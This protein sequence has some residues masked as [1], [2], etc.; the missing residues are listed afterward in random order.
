MDVSEASAKPMPSTTTSPEQQ[1]MIKCAELAELPATALH[2]M[3]RTGQG[4][5]PELSAVKGSGMGVGEL[6]DK[7]RA[8]GSRA[9]EEAFAGPSGGAARGTGADCFRL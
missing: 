9:W 1:L 5:P 7:L 8:I 3:I 4:L 6:R 2:D